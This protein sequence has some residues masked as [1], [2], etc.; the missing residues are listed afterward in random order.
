MVRRLAA[1][2]TIEGRP[3]GERPIQRVTEDDLEVFIKHLTVLGRAS[4]TRNHHV[5]LISTGR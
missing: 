1:F 2:Q 4:S 3:L 5:Q